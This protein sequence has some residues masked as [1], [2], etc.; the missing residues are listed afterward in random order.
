MESIRVNERDFRF[1]KFCC[2]QKFLLREQVEAWFR[3]EGKIADKDSAERVARRQLARFK[4]QGWLADR[5]SGFA[6]SKIW[7]L[8]KTGRSLLK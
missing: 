8:T 2:E 3:C 6:A 5:P 7:A 1:L 4:S